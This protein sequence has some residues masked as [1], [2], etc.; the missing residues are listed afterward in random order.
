MAKV[1]NPSLEAKRQNIIIYSENKNL[2][3]GFTHIAR[4]KKL[5]KKRLMN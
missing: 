3:G 5:K 2:K 1:K 4:I